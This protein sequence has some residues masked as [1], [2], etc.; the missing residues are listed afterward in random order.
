MPVT[1]TSLP[2][3]AVVAIVNK[4]RTSGLV[5]ARRSCADLSTSGR[6]VDVNPVGMA[7]TTSDAGEATFNG[8]ALGLA[9]RQRKEIIMI[10]FH[11]GA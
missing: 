2:G 6:H 9:N 3:A 4:W 11:V 1:R 5:C 10:A 7:N 8:Y